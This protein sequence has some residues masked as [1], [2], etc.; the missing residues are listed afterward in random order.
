[1]WVKVDDTR[2]DTGAIIECDESNNLFRAGIDTDSVN[3]PPRFT[4]KLP[5]WVEAL[6]TYRY[7]M[8]FLDPDGDPL[9]FSLPVAPTGMVIHST[10]GVLAWNPGLEQIGQ[11]D[12]GPFASKTPASG[13]VMIQS[14]HHLH[15]GTEHRTGFH[16]ATALR[17]AGSMEVIR[18]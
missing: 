15:H 4:G 14:V 12:V 3:Y 11:H 18:L 5:S 16:D 10:L 2:T 17:H 8:K 6:S 7:A 1:L 13:N 9:T